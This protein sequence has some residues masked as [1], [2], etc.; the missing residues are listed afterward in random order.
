MVKRSELE[1]LLVEVAE[2]IS[3][4][5]THTPEQ[6]RRKEQLLGTFVG[7]A[8]AIDELPEQPRRSV[9]TMVVEN[10]KP[11]RFRLYSLEELEELPALPAPSAVK[12]RKS[13]K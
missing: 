13:K 12:R 9:V 10:V 4:A 5:Q 8:A 2:Q 6:R 11:S 3:Q 1:Q 7:L